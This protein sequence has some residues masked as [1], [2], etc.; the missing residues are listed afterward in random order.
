[1]VKSRFGGCLE[2]FPDKR[3]EFGSRAEADAFIQTDSVCIGTGDGETD[4]SAAQSYEAREGVSKEF[5]TNASAAQNRKDAQLR[6]MA[7]A[8]GDETGKR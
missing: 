1:M 8:W 4:G 2:I 7:G 6:D 3:G 5:I